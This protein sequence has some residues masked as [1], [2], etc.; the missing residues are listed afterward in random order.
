VGVA[1]LGALSGLEAVQRRLHP[2]LLADLRAELAPLERALGE[3]LSRFRDAAPDRGLEGFHRAFVC[4]S[5]F[6]LE[7]ITRFCRQAPAQEAIAEILAS[8]QA[9]AHALE[10]LYP[11]HRFEPIGRFFVESAFH[12]RLERL[13]REPRDGLSVGLH[14]SGDQ[15]ADARRG[16]LC[17]YVPESCDGGLEMP[18]V[19]ALHGGGGDGRGFLWSW[20]REAR[21]RGFMVLAPT[22]SGDTWSF[23]N[24]HIDG[25][26]LRSMVAYV[27][28]RWPVKRSSILLT[29]LSDGATFALIEGLRADS[30]FTA[31]APFSGVLHPQLLADGSLARAA[32][33]RV[34]LVHGSL[35][36]MFPVELARMARQRLEEAGADVVFREIADLSHTYARDENGRVLSWFDSSLALT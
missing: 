1:T 27:C 35:D 15:H 29:G 21:G 9:F 17:L 13:D 11:L 16:E 34:Y 25:D 22:A 7:S 14:Y 6:A 12:D 3:T 10:A 36:W 18:L 2:P 30:P 24:P 26:M 8:M 28:D 31:L 19:V 32:G 4:G 20:L 5:S 33:R 23:A